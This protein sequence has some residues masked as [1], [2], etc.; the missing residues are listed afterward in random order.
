[1]PAD[2]YI[3]MSVC[4]SHV[5]D[6]LQDYTVKVGDFGLTRDVYHREYYRMTG[7]APL[8]IRWMSPEAIGDGLFTC[9]WST[10]LIMFLLSK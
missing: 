6:G 3:C 8:P 5:P 7:A 9:Q 4:L 10:M 1:M 2:L